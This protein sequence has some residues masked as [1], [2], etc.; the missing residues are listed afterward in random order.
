MDATMTMESFNALLTAEKEDNALLAALRK[1][2]SLEKP[3]DV[4]GASAQTM[5]LWYWR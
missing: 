5:A 3:D 4:R 2:M 1:L